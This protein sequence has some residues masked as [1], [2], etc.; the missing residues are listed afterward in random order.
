M[1]PERLALVL[2]HGPGGSGS[3]YLVG[4]QLVLTALHVVRVD[5][6]WAREVTVRV[7]HPRYGADPV[8]RAAQVC[9]P[10]PTQAV[11]ADDALDVALLWLEEAVPTEGGPV[12]WG[13]PAGVVPVPFEG[14]GFPAFAAERGGVEAQAEHLRGVLPVVSTNS[15][16]WVLDCP[17]WPAARSDGRRPWAGAS[18]SAIFCRGR[19]VG[20]AV[21]DDR[22]TDWRRLHA[23]P[24]H[25]ALA[26]AGFADLVTRHGHSGTGL[27]VEEVKAGTRMPVLADRL[28]ALPRG[29]GRAVSARRRRYLLGAAALATA[30]VCAA[31]FL[32]EDEKEPP[33]SVD[34]ISFVDVAKG[35]YTFPSTM[36]LSPGQLAKL[37]DEEYGGGRD[38][39]TW[40]SDNH[41]VPARNVL[42]SLTI[43]GQSD[44]RVRITGIR[45]AKKNCTTPLRGNTLFMNGGT[46]GGESKTR[47][48]FYRLDEQD[49]VPTDSEGNPYFAK[50]VLYL[51]HGESET[52]AV[53]VTANVRACDFSFRFN[54]VVPGAKEPV[55]QDVD[56]HGQPFRL[57][58]MAVDYEAAQPYAKYKAI[59]VG[60]VAAPIETHGDLVAA[61]P[62]TYD[63]TADSITLP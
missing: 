63:G 31:A 5:G 15:T 26:M 34:D 17:V 33:L 13:R 62:R 38:F 4:P 32:P 45:L 37:D 6:R 49:P 46:N 43:S 61:D 8:Q 29:L 40:F 27:A 57:T 7:G 60:G 23:A 14:V 18:G 55:P 47:P 24:I 20:I 51:D 48:L 35:D 10:D 44:K 19:L 50:N 3:G 12:C 41:G 28:L 58:P 54:V 39:M 59:Y 36:K 30:V 25:E 52:L 2:T 11:P 1:E 53:L 9:W 22:A 56:D 16:G 42:I 21:Q